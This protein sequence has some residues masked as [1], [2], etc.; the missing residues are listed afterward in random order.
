MADLNAVELDETDSE[1]DEVFN[2]G[3]LYDEGN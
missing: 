3:R 1:K 2:E